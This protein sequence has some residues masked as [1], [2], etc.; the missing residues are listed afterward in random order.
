MNITHFSWEYPPAIWGGLGTFAL[1]IT[2]KQV[3]RGNKVLVFSLNNQNKLKPTETWKG[4]QVIRPKTYDL[5]PAF[6]LFANED[7]QSW[8]PNFKFFSDV[9][10]YNISSAS[11]L[12][13]LHRKQNGGSTDII[14]G[15]D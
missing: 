12:I 14:D 9:V 7:V 3:Q 2:Q 4:V 5:T 13:S 8:G 15:H 10:N 6:R 1:E 11:Q